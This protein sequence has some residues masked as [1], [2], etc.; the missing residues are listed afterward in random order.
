LPRAGR[1]FIHEKFLLNWERNVDMTTSDY[2]TI[3][4]NYEDYLAEYGL[5]EE[6]NKTRNY[7]QSLIQGDSK[8]YFSGNET[9]TERKFLYV[10]NEELPF[11]HEWGYKMQ[12][13]MPRLLTSILK[14]QKTLDHVYYWSWTA[15]VADFFE[16][17]DRRLDRAY[18][19]LMHTILAERIGGFSHGDTDEEID[20]KRRQMADF[21]QLTN[22]HYREMLR[23]KAQLAAFV[24]YPVLEGLMK[25]ILSD[26]I[27][28]DGEIKPGKTLEG[29]N[30]DYDNG[31]L[32]SSLR[33]LL[34][35]AEQNTLDSS[36]VDELGNLTSEIEKFGDGNEWYSMIYNWRNTLL[37]GEDSWDFQ[38]SILA[39]LISFLV[40][41]EVDEAE[42]CDK[43]KD[44]IESFRTRV[45]VPSF[46]AN[47]FP[48]GFYPPFDGERL[49]GHL[50]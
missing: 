5:G 23:Q 7:T 41:S 36:V 18:N 14:V 50:E 22:R 3:K 42:Y 39:N 35:H 32:C 6:N 2:E 46:A 27:K 43:R 12:L 8:W 25:S 40:W 9:E 47:M 19:L 1:G 10:H 20:R 24:S 30:G 49:R 37:H 38:Y 45:E 11:P 28:P 33:D 44:I 16:L 26:V 48:Y 29:V 4:A 31:K 21:D 34:Y 15:E 13:S 17:F